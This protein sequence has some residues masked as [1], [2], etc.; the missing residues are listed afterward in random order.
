MPWEI[1]QANQRKIK[2]VNLFV[3]AFCDTD[4]VD[5]AH[6]YRGRTNFNTIYI[7]F[8]TLCLCIRRER[9]WLTNLKNI[10]RLFCRS[11]CVRSCGFFLL[12]YLNFIFDSRVN[13]GDGRAAPHM[14]YFKGWHRTTP[15]VHQHPPD[16]RQTKIGRNSRP[17]GVSACVVVNFANE[18]SDEMSH[19]IWHWMGFTIGCQ[20]IKIFSTNEKIERVQWHK[21]QIAISSISQG[22]I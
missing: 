16:Q 11:V 6:F 17:V 21:Q 5:D 20:T 13:D 7:Q 10:C 12:F 19:A 9:N 14:K 2:D 15:S 3:C 8:C 4:V 22:L 18:R 1:V